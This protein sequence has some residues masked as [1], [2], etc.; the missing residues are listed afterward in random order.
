ML[1]S[2]PRGALARAFLALVLLLGLCA[3]TTASA[4]ARAG[5][6]HLLHHA[7]LSAPHLL[8]VGSHRHHRRHIVTLEE[9]ERGL[10]AAKP[11]ITIPGA[12]EIVVFGDR[13][14]DQAGGGVVGLLSDMTTTVDYGLDRAT[15]GAKSVYRLVAEKARVIGVPVPMA[16][17]ATRL[18]SGGSCGL[19][20]GVGERG[21]LQIRP[22]TA[23]AMGLRPHNCAEWIDAGLRYFKLAGEMHGWGCGG[24]SAYNLGTYTRGTYCTGYGRTILALAG[25]APTLGSALIE[26]RWSVRTGR[27]HH[28]RHWRA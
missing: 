10:A 26:A 22:Q 17:A 3:V 6:H 4:E 19:V 16:L 28:H 11:I 1:V 2:H 9:F 23:W 8:H 5:R 12:P 25:G 14:V 7:K 15:L 27:R 20:G 13:H 18:E 24:A 21:P